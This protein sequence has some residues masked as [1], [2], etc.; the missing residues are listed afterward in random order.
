ML[1][2]GAL[3]GAVMILTMGGKGISYPGERMPGPQKG[4]RNWLQLRVISTLRRVVV[5]VKS[6]GQILTA[7]FRGQAWGS[8]A[9]SSVG[10]AN[11]TG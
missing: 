2:R 11:D 9:Y 6:P 8:S 3:Q 5:T 4:P 1:R 7:E 10:L